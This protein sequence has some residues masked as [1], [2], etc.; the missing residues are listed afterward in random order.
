MA[1]L[2]SF[3][4]LPNPRKRDNKNYSYKMLSIWSPFA[5]T[6]GPPSSLGYS[7]T[8][9]PVALQQKSMPSPPGL[10]RLN[11]QQPSTTSG[12]PKS[13]GLVDGLPNTQQKQ[14]SVSQTFS[15]SDETSPLREPLSFPFV[16][17]LETRESCKEG[18][19]GEYSPL[20]L[21]HYCFQRNPRSQRLPWV[22][23]ATLKKA[24]CHLPLITGYT[25]MNVDLATSD[26]VDIH[27]DRCTT[28]I[29]FDRSGF[30][31]HFELNYDLEAVKFSIFFRRAPLK[32]GVGGK[33]AQIGVF[34]PQFRFVILALGC[35][36]SRAVW[37]VVKY[38]QLLPLVFC[39]SN[40]VV[41]VC[42][43]LEREFTKS[44]HCVPRWE[45]HWKALPSEM[46]FPVLKK[47]EI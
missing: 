7:S 8:N 11:Q 31:H 22:E 15:D 18:D 45:S 41:V 27:V 16:S 43:A 19:L 12:V 34:S 1:G 28:A 46:E 32:F 39:Q 30:L 2:N 35:W 44:C 3:F 5:K 33:K 40:Q 38:T 21:G 9:S 26:F 37:C 42:V 36:E 25:P 20:W 29:Q 6:Q 23:G 10:P 13:I 14:R 17:R 47:V 4:V 24:F